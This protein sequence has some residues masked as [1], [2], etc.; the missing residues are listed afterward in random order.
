MLRAYSGLKNKVVEDEARV[1]LTHHL[2]KN[3]VNDMPVHEWEIPSEENLPEY[4]QA[5]SRPAN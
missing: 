1:I 2:L 4:K 3:Q 5:A